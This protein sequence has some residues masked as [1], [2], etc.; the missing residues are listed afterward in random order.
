MTDGTFQSPEKDTL[1]DQLVKAWR[2]AVYIEWLDICE[3]PRTCSGPDNISP[4]NPAPCWSYGELEYVDRDKVLLIRERRGDI[5][6][7]Q[8]FP[9]GVITKV[10]QMAARVDE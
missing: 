5:V 10:T 3:E 8:A 2:S 1:F 4:V 7:V 6:D 9:T